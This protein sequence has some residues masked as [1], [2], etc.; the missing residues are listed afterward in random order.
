M[1]D[2]VPHGDTQ[3]AK[4]QD[5][6]PQPAHFLARGDNKYTP[7]IALDE[8]P[9]GITLAGVPMYV[10]TEEILKREVTIYRPASAKHEKPYE[11]SIELPEQ[12]EEGLAHQ[13]IK[14]P[15]DRALNVSLPF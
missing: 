9:E 12:E 4:V 5:G 13:P 14:V 6:S 2:K 3:D 11:V 10:T 7:L 1:A 8:L 15:S